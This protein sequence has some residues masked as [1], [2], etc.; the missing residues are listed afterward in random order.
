MLSCS[1]GLLFGQGERWRENRQAF[2]RALWRASVDETYEAIIHRE[3]DFV[4]GQISERLG[5]PLEIDTLLLPALSRRQVTL[6]L[7]E[8]LARDDEEMKMLIQQMQNLE[9]VDLTSKST[10][11]FLKV[12]HFR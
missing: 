5:S 6:L 10:Q 3:A 4:L 1:P 7:G 12:K 8:P 9:E 11:M 2:V